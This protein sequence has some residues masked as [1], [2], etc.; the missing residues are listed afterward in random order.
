ME[1]VQF[2]KCS[3]SRQ[4]MTRGRWFN[5]EKRLAAVFIYSV[6]RYQF[7]TELRLIPHV[8]WTGLGQGNVSTSLAG[9]TAH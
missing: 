5:T 1:N 3:H 8:G 4:D 2:A 9:A 7:P 6:S